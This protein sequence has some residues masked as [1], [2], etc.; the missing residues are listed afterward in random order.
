MTLRRAHRAR[1]DVNPYIAVADTALNVVLVMVF[2][3]GALT[4]IGRVSWEDVRYKEAQQAFEASLRRLVEPA[5]RPILTPGKND[6][7]GTQRWRFRTA[8]LFTPNT[9]ELTPDG[10]AT[11]LRFARV[12]RENQDKWRRIRIEGHTVRTTRNDRWEEAT[13]RAAAVARLLVNEGKVAP[14]FLTTAGRGGQDPLAHLAPDDP[15]QARIE[16]V[17]EYAGQAADGGSGR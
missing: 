4:A 10:R 7:P 15:A 6:P 13:N 8:Q 16:V 5:R 9:A 17:L 2:F 1:E 14:W 11:L 3:V 12:L